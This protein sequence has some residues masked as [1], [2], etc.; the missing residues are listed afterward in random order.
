MHKPLAVAQQSHEE[1]APDIDKLLEI[2]DLVHSWQYIQFW[3]TESGKLDAIFV[4][5]LSLGSRRLLCRVTTASSRLLSVDPVL[6]L[7]RIETTLEWLTIGL[8]SISTK[9]FYVIA[10]DNSED[11]RELRMGGHKMLLYLNWTSLHCF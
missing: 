5:E 2:S 10:V 4:H 1:E 11:Q 3:G 8:P 9:R 7:L 6:R